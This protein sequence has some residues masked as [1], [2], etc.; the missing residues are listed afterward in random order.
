MILTILELYRIFKLHR[1][2]PIYYIISE[3]IPK[4]QLLK[5]SM[6]GKTVWIVHPDSFTA[7]ER[8]CG[9]VEKF[10]VTR[11]MILDAIDELITTANSRQGIDNSQGGQR[12]ITR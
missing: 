3:F 8:I 1:K 11:E 2:E 7:F 12:G 5:A 4:D 9:K 10:E 6:H